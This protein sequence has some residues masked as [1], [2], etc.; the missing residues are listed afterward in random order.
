M[1]YA[2]IDIQDKQ[3]WLSLGDTVTVYGQSGEVGAKV[4]MENV[5]LTNLSDQVDV[6]Q[7][8]VAT[9]AIFEI[10]ANQK[11]EK[12][13]VSK[14]K[15]KSRYR[16]VNGHR[17]DQSVLKLIQL[18]DLKLAPATPKVAKAVKTKTP[19][20]K[21]KKEVGQKAKVVDTTTK[22]TKEAKPKA[23]AKSKTS[24]KATDL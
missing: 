3:F 20:T 15:S 23:T 22:V 14:F 8:K 6:G 12:I 21:V 2:I 13:R 1:D 19:E 18:G 17:Q 10:I 4:T 24:K 9:K 11:S 5:L 7:S 16:K